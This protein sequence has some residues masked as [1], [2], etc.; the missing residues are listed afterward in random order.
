MPMLNDAHSISELFPGVEVFAALAP[1][2]AGLDDLLPEERAAVA[3]AVPKRRREFAAGRTLARRLLADLGVP[4]EPLLNDDDRVP[5][6]PPGIVGSIAHC[7][8]LCIV[9]VARTGAGVRG[10]GLD[11]EP[12]A[13]LESE[14]WPTVARPEELAW[15]RAQTAGN[16]G[17][18]ARLHFAAKEA[19]YKSVYP[20]IRRSLEFDEVALNF[21][22]ADRRFT[23]RLLPRDSGAWRQVPATG[24]GRW[25]EHAGHLVTA[26]NWA[27]G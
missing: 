13:P 3:G 4:D 19:V 23:Y 22:L 12:H 2:D 6:W 16:P 14:L 20:A 15:I 11:I 5:R 17:R 18:A 9:A 21:N 10:I 27:A 24:A 8:T 26:V 25:I 7:D 1:V